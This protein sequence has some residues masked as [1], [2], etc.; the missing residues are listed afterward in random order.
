MKTFNVKL[1]YKVVYEAEVQVT[2][3][4]VVEAM[5]KAVEACR[6]SRPEFKE[7]QATPPAI[8]SVKES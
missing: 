2:A 5:N 7:A 6:N 4:S 8:V 3:D 1:G